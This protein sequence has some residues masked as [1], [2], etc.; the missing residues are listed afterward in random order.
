MKKIYKAIKAVVFILLCVASLSVVSTMLQFEHE[1]EPDLTMKEFYQLE[2][3]T[4]QILLVGT[5]HNTMGFSPI[6]CYKQTQITSFNLSTAKQPI[7]LSYYLLEEALKTQSPEVIICDVA[8]LFYKKSDI[9]IAKFR[10]VIDSMPLSMTKLKLADCYAYYNED[11]KKIFSVGEAI[12]PIYYYHDRWKELTEEEFNVDKAVPHLKG[13]VLRINISEM[14][15]DIADQDAKAA[16]EIEKDPDDAPK[17]SKHNLS[18]L[19]KM[20]ELCDE[21]NI[22]L[23]LTITPTKKWNSYKR[24]V[25]EQVCDKYGMDFL[26]MNQTDGTVVD[27]TNN[28]AD[29]NH[30]NAS[31]AIKTTKYLY[32][33]VINNYGVKGKFNQDYEDSI[34]YYDAYYNNMI[35]YN[36]ET[37]FNKYLSLLNENKKDLTIFI[38]AKGDIV[39]GL[40]DNDVAQL[41]SLGCKISFDDSYRDNSYLAVID[42][43]NLVYEE[44]DKGS[45][46]YKYELE[47]GSKVKMSS[48]EEFEEGDP[49]INIDDMEYAINGAGLNIV[50]YDKESN[51]VIDSVSFNTHDSQKKWYRSDER[52]LEL[53]MFKTYREWVSENY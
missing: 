22:K 42:E 38:S 1:M 3:D 12:C 29:G 14:E 37:D 6:E 50:I 30:V 5:S 36:M 17:I 15:Y 8:N 47:N 2:E 49:I 53:Y 51:L 40:Q 43:G 23:L 33:Y 44:A 46:S 13:Q 11:V 31:G 7:E 35:K 41:Q 34:K 26:D 20:K 45:I 10:Y 48:E 18:Y 16:K 9:N 21:N 24:E 52:S 39:E 32:D 27:Y 19:I 4:A 25:I 28:M